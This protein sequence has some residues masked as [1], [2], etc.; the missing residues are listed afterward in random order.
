MRQQSWE[1]SLN[2]HP[3]ENSWGSGSHVS[4]GRQHL[5]GVGLDPGV[6]PHLARG[7]CS[8]GQCLSSLE[9]MF[10]PQKAPMGGTS[11]LPS[12]C[13]W[14]SQCET[15]LKG[16]FPT[17]CSRLR[18]QADPPSHCMSSPPLFLGTRSCQLR[19][20]PHLKLLFMFQSPIFWFLHLPVLNKLLLSRVPI[21]MLLNMVTFL[22]PH[23][24]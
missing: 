19:L 12:G 9:I 23:L 3:K 5:L 18:F 8:E 11:L 10:W 13:I 20:F 17:S 2:K 4:R 16:G 24:T 22:C 21:C 1:S 14:R 7:S 15:L 6:L